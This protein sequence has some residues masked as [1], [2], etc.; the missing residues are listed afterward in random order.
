[1]EDRGW[2]REKG[3]ALLAM[4]EGEMVGLRMRSNYGR[5]FGNIV[6]SARQ[7]DAVVVASSARGA[8]RGSLFVED[9]HGP[10]ESLDRR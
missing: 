3:W 5:L 9:A 8:R 6:V 7:A 10:G 4:R 2:R 1:M